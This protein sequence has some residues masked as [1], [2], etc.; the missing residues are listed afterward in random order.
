MCHSQIVFVSAT[1]SSHIRSALNM[2][3]SIRKHYLTESIIVYDLGIED[4]DSV[5]K[6]EFDGLDVDLQKFAFDKYPKHFRMSHLNGSYAW[7]SVIINEVMSY[8]DGEMVIWMDAGNL[9]HKKFWL[10]ARV[11]RIYGIFCNTA[12][13][14]VNNW[15]HQSTLDALN[16]KRRLKMFSA[17]FIAIH[18]T[19]KSIKLVQKWKDYSMIEHVIAPEGVNLKSHRFDQSILSILIH[20]NIR[21]LAVRRVPF[22][23][24]YSTHNDID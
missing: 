2:I 11:A 14:T 3:K 4:G 17:A 9:C 5:A 20:K 6:V 1:D 7:K 15:T 21:L 24:S 10:E 18:K 13:G 23:S 8:S 16:V 22:I 19:E 12:K